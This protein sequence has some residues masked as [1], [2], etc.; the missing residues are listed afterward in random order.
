[1]ELL[2][3]D[4]DVD[5]RQIVQRA[6]DQQGVRISTAATGAEAIAHAIRSPIDLVVLDL[7][8]P[9]MTG[10]EVLEELRAV[11]P[12]VYV[13]M[14]TG[15]GS[16][17]DRVLGLVS[18]A[19]DYMVKPFSP[20]ELAARVLAVLRRFTEP[21]PDEP[22]DLPASPRST[23]HV[24]PAMA[25]FQPP[26]RSRA[27]DSLDAT[28]VITGTVV[29]YAS[30][31]MTT[32][33]GAAS[34]DDVVGHDVFEFIAPQ[35]IG[36]TRARH[37]QARAGH[38][39]RPELLTVTR[40]DGVEV[41]VEIASA[42][43]LW[44]GEPASQITL[45]DLGGDT[46]PLRELAMGF[47][48]NVPD[49]VI[50]TTE[51][52]TIQSFNEAAEALYGWS[53]AEV[54][55]RSLR[56]TIG[57]DLVEQDQAVAHQQLLAAGRWYG[58]ELQRARDGTPLL[59]RSSKT[60]LRDASGSTVGIISVNR[61]RARE[62]STW[63]GN[64]ADPDLGLDSAIRVGLPRGE[65]VVH[66]QPVVQ[67]ATGDLL[68]VEALVRW[69]H[70]DRG[71]LPPAEFIVAAERSGV[72]VALGRV[73]L[74]EACRQA[75]AWR[76]AGHHLYIAVNLSARQLTDPTLTDWIAEVMEETAMPEQGLWLEVTET[77]LVQDLDQASAALH[78]LAGLGACV[79]IDDFGTGWASL[80]YLREFPVHA[81]KIDRVFVAGL[82]TGSRDETI[83]GSM[84][85]LGRELDV[86][87]IAEGVETEE[88]RDILLEL[89]CEIGQGYLFG[90]A[91]PARAVDHALAASSNGPR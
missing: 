38:W 2:V 75:Q 49:A 82:G 77:A 57:W 43:V 78:R 59:V 4:D 76:Q 35:S 61:P 91:Q 53:E 74:E 87:V 66:Y 3:V 1:M 5:V 15:A 41:L 52:L 27:A 30:D 86:A 16:E 12:S 25:P 21:G 56:E 11:H 69:Q 84:L 7:H 10:L 50:V 65:F 33:L 64:G 47:S 22:L 20:R 71:L 28:V 46:S 60:V 62:T 80:T 68:G 48:S 26:A 32:L 31:E 14:L 44:E 55:G 67:L 73:V 40:V 81:L 63:S 13:I 39:P 45:W 8:L 23:Y 70:P 85:S 19:D 89:G 9:D 58:E 79:S 88:Q 36:A 83:V 72:I 42:P 54:V 37:E 18:G 6:L 34:V 17:S 29:R 24:T 51:D 90:R